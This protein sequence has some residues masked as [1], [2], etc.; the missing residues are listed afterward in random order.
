MMPT[1]TQP[2]SPA[3]PRRAR[4]LVA[5]LLGLGFVAAAG[6]FG[7]RTWSRAA[8][9]R[10]ALALAETGP[11]ETALPAL[12]RCLE[13]DPDDAEL[14]WAV[15]KLKI[16]TG[17]P[18]ADVEP[19][20]DRLA[21]LIPDDP[22]VFRT[23]LD[24]YR[25]LGRHADAFA[26][27]RRAVELEPND[28]RLRGELAGVALS[29]GRF[30]DAAD[31]FRRLL[32]AG[33]A[34]PRHELQTGLA[35]AAWELGDAAEAAR[36]IEQALAAAPD[37]PVALTLRGMIHSQAGEDEAAIAVFRRVRPSSPGEQEIVLY[38]LA[39]S[40]NRTGKTDEAKKSFTELAAV[41]N[42]V[43]FLTDARQRPT[44]LGLQVRAAEALMAANR[45]DDA[46]QVLEEALSRLGPSR[47]VFDA[48]VV[49]YDRLGRPDLARATLEKARQLP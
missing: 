29:A 1:P 7:A 5:A 21:K 19:D 2:A 30:D 48:L 31:E 12:L 26:A 40:L 41:Q 49:C 4:L 44:D 28:D 34:I 22:A 16:R 43:R 27:A 36:L 15:V 10:E 46:R 24:L 20:L 18:V 8:E 35:R 6:Y 17:A 14:L 11:T 25:R 3:A 13:R 47:P 23:R 9:R 37:F 42:A 39:L 38:H 32:A 45:P 33:S